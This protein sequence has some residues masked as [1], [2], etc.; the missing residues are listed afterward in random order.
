MNAW[1]GWVGGW[2]DGWTARLLGPPCIASRDVD[3][4]HIITIQTHPPPHTQNKKQVIKGRRCGMM[5]LQPVI[6]GDLL[7]DRIV[8]C[9]RKGSAKDLGA[10]LV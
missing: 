5:P 10:C 1:G 6:D 2:M 8:E 7:P 3:R 9:W 4:N